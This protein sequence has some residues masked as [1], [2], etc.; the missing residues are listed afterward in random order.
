MMK[1]VLLHVLS[2]DSTVAPTSATFMHC[3]T[4]N[5]RTGVF[6]SLL[7]LLL[8]VSSELVAH[9]YALSEAGLAPT[10]HINV[11]RLLKKGAFQEYGPDE[12][13]RKCTRMVGARKESMHALLVK[14]KTKWGGAEGYFTREVGLSRDDLERLKSLFTEENV[15]HIVDEH[16]EQ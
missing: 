12:A 4:G 11:E 14:V 6:V 8:G 3:T 16:V 13:R 1:S 10:R 5:N 15:E 7:L 2:L 9:E